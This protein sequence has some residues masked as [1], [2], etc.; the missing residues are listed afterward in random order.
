MHQ[1]YEVITSSG[2]LQDGTAW[3]G[4]AHWEF[5]SSDDRGDVHHVFTKVAARVEQMLNS[6]PVVLS[7]KDLGQVETEYAD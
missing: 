6:D 7:Y 3:H 1:M 5:L 2:D 4:V